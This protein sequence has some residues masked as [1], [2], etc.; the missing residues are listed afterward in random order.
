[1]NAG[2]V[3]TY[4]LFNYYDF[5]VPPGPAGGEKWPQCWDAAPKSAFT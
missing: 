2:T 4:E 1:M 5:D 3:R